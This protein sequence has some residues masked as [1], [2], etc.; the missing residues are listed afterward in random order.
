LL[1]FEPIKRAFTIYI[2]NGIVLKNL[3]NWIIKNDPKQN[4]NLKQLVI[5]PG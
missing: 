5:D 4:R 3:E 2:E 1:R